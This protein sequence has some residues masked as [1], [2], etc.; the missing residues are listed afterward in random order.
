MP[1]LPSSN[2]KQ[3]IQGAPALHVPD[4]KATATFYRDVLGFNWDFGDDDYSVVW[5]GKPGVHFVKGG[6]EPTRGYLFPL[7]GEGR[8][9]GANRQGRRVASPGARAA[10]RPDRR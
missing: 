10:A 2:P 6:Q 9:R 4:V 1:N 3:F 5:R 8:P 7:G